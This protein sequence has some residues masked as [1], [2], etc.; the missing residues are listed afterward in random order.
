MLDKL[1]TSLENISIAATRNDVE[2][3]F[4][5]FIEL[6]EAKY[7]K[8]VGCLKKNCDVLLDFDDFPAEHWKRL[9]T[10]NPVESTFAIVRHRTI[11]SKGKTSSQKSSPM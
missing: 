11:R 4:D 7:D 1:P 9:R 5:H 2:A 8:A 6:Y 10:T 3:A